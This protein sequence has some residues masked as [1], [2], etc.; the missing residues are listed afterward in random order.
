MEIVAYYLRYF[1]I[2]CMFGLTMALSAVD[3]VLHSPP[4]WF[5]EQFQDTLVASIPGLDISWRL[6][7]ALELVVAV[8]V[9]VSIVMREFLPGSAKPWLKGALGVSAVTFMMLGVGQRISSEFDGASSL[10]FYFGATMATLLVVFADE[11]AEDRADVPV[12]T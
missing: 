9:I 7:G 4:E 8:L 11:R 10:F 5:Q 3:K 1:A 6:A 2:Y 12:T